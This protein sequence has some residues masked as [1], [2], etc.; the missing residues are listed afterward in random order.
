MRRLIESCD[1]TIHEHFLLS[2]NEAIAL[3]QARMAHTKES[4]DTLVSVSGTMASIGLALVGILSA[5]SS[6]SH[7]ETIA[8]DFFLFS[9]LGFLVTATVGYLAQK[10]QADS[11]VE[12]LASMAEWIFTIALILLLVG[13]FVL[14]YTEV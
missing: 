11:R 7:V 13:G 14:V 8:D 3:H 6:L 12:K 2:L 5:K 9:S 4:L 10:K 1:E